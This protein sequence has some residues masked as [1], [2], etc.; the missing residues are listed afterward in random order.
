MKDALLS[1]SRL[2]LLNRRPT[3][4]RRNALVAF[5][6]D[7]RL[8]PTEPEEKNALL[9]PSRS[10]ALNRRATPAERNS[11]AAFSVDPSRFDPDPDPDLQKRWR[12]WPPGR[13]VVRACWH[14]FLRGSKT[15][16]L[17]SRAKRISGRAPT[18]PYPENTV[19]GAVLAS[20]S[21]KI[22]APSGSTPDRKPQGHDA[23]RAG[24]MRPVG[25]GSSKLRRSWPASARTRRGRSA[26]IAQGRLARKVQVDGRRCSSF[27]EVCFPG[28]VAM[29]GS[30]DR[31]TGCVARHGH[32]P[33]ND[34]PSRAAPMA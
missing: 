12:G 18:A 33:T 32:C 34:R 2:A 7:L 26:V 19:T 28:G 1:P 25:G 3:P 17:R 14:G 20:W 21:H 27:L 10:T 15:S 24:R 31:I 22:V 6:L 9:S 11:L 23:R 8:K 16:F 4:A 5:W 13:D 30:G 29:A